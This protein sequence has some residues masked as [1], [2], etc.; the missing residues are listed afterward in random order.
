MDYYDRF[1]TRAEKVLE[2]ANHIA[3]ISS[4]ND[5]MPE[6]ILMGIGIEG[7]CEAASFLNMGWGVKSDYLR[8]RMQEFISVVIEHTDKL[9]GPE[10]QIIGPEIPAKSH[11]ERPYNLE[12]LN[13][14]RYA[15][16]Y[17]ENKG[18]RYVCTSDILY[19]MLVIASNE[20][21]V[22]GVLEEYGLRRE[23]LEIMVKD[24]HD[25]GK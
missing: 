20:G 16:E 5:I 2:I 11:P 12:A 21:N 19:S 13:I 24:W 1:S 10:T 8:S 15:H 18:N 6:H 17:T 22:S 14:L 4:E 23:E 9:Y 25:K 7:R 3:R